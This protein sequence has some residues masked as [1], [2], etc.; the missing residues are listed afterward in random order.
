MVPHR[1]RLKSPTMPSN[2]PIKQTVRPVTQL[3]CASCAPARPAAYRVRSADQNGL[4]NR[5]ANVIATTSE[6]VRGSRGRASN[7]MFRFVQWGWGALTLVAMFTGCSGP[8]RD[9]QMDEAFQ[10]SQRSFEEL[11][12][13]FRT[14]STL[15]VV[16]ND[17]VATTTGTQQHVGDQSSVIA[18]TRW[19]EYRAKFRQLNLR[20]GISR[21]TQGPCECYLDSYGT[22]FVFS[23]ETKG[24]AYCASEP[25]PLVHDLDQDAIQSKTLTFRKLRDNW[26][27]FYEF[28]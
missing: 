17:W 12:D 6:A 10:R 14:D 16:R 2:N 23:S 4:K 5:M 22:G 13:M 8:P 27:L 15:Q 9:G 11:R 25:T 20:G 3:A 18:P 1:P 19:D 26:Y 24:Y 28:T 7:R 21:S